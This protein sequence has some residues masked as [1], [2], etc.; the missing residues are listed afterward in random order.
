M[1]R[2]VKGHKFNDPIDIKKATQ[3]IAELQGYIEKSINGND[4]ELSI[5]RRICPQC[6]SRNLKTVKEKVLVN[7]ELQWLKISCDLLKQLSVTVI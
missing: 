7:P 5:D 6:N 3:F 1:V 4:F 2:L